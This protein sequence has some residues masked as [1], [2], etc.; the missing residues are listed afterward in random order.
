MREK[1]LLRA[2]SIADVDFVKDLDEVVDPEKLS[3]GQK[4]RIA[5]ARALV[6]QPDV[7]LLDEALN[8]VDENTEARILAK[9]RSEIT[10]N[11]LRMVI[12]V[13]HRSSTLGLVDKVYEL[14]QGKLLQRTLPREEDTNEEVA[15]KPQ[16]GR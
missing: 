11:Q 12:I 6:M 10:N 4:Q 13:T 16:Q 7:L 14:K 3:D 8:A 15:D 9:L 1:A 5:L 2:L